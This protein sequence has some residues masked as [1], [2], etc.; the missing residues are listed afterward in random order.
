MDYVEIQD[1]TPIPLSSD[2]EII[3]TYPRKVIDNLELSFEEAKL[4][5]NASV[6]VEEK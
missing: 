2:I 5:P 6:V 1:L 3:N 4:V